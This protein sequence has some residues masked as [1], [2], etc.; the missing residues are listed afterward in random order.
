MPYIGRDFSTLNPEAYTPLDPEDLRRIR[1]E[2]ADG[3]ANFLGMLGAAMAVIPPTVSE[4]TAAK[5]AAALSV[6]P[7][8]PS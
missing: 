6:D 4:E 8:Q 2:L 1:R 3:T 5:S 7:S